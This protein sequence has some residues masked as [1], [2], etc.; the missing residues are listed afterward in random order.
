MPQKICQTSQTN[1][2]VGRKIDN[3]ESSSK[4]NDKC[5][6]FVVK[7]FLSVV[8]PELFHCN[9]CTDLYCCVCSIP[10]IYL[11]YVSVALLLRLCFTSTKTK[12]LY[13]FFNSYLILC[14]SYASTDNC[15][16]KELLV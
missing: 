9:F 13:N 15:V 6:W 8:K 11:R 7:Y 4:S 16:T 1:E 14:Y 10:M 12:L 5:M 3:D 2:A